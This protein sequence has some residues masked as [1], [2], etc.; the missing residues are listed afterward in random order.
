MVK[1]EEIRK[2][3]L[4]LREA[5]EKGEW[6]QKTRNITKRVT[7]HP[8]F[9]QAEEI[10]CYMDFRGEVGTRRIIEKAGE[11]NKKV[12]IPKT[13]GKTMEFYYISSFRETHPGRFG[14]LEPDERRPASGEEGLI[15]MPGAAFD[16]ELHR[17]GY[18]GGF[19][20]R[21]LEAHTG[22]L[23][24]ALAFECQVLPGIPQEEYDIRPRVLVTEMRIETRYME[25]EKEE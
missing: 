15:L 2:K 7:S 3:V 20:D 9:L 17:I 21:Y 16:H 24:M 18:G 13:V 1:K 4:S 10:Y 14:I 6:D 25:G 19:Y 11:M 5:M 22:L 12:A 23:S 8:L